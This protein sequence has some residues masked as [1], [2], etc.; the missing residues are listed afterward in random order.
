MNDEAIKEVA[1][2]RQRA[3]ENDLTHGYVKPCLSG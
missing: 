2:L 1:A 3:L